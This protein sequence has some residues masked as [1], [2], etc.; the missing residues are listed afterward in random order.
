MTVLLFARFVA[1]QDPPTTTPDTRE[2][3]TLLGSEVTPGET[4]RLSLF[5]G[6]SFS[7]ADLQTPVF[8]IHGLKPGPTLCLTAGVHGD[9]VNGVEITRRVVQRLSPRELSGTVV[10]VPI[11]NLS[12]F[13]RGSRYLP[14][15]RDLNRYFPG[16]AFGSAASRIA[17]SLFTG[18]VAHCDAL[19]DLHTGSFH[20]TNVHQVRCDLTHADVVSLAIGLG[21]P[22]VIHNLGREGTLRRS[23]VEAGVPAVTIEAGEPARLSEE[24][25]LG[26]VEDIERLLTHLGMVPR[27][28]AAPRKPQIFYRH[29]HWVRTD[30]GGILVGRVTLGARVVRDQVLGTVVDPLSEEVSE[31][32]ATHDGLV[33]GKAFDQLVMPGFAA[34]HVAL[35]DGVEEGFEDSPPGD[36]ADLD[37][38]LD[39][40][41]E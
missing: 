13:R 41:P 17:H 19:V 34:F 22:V 25:V 40:R 9:E 31:V 26:G 23:A 37:L 28:V 21:A 29:T 7:G 30:A 11:A 36:D 20:R 16:R 2:A 24:A 6:E 33:I 8:V 14:D 32:R 4:R 39:E 1:A 15:R 38:D 35:K 27:T 3:F 10:A 18:V 12:A 5:V